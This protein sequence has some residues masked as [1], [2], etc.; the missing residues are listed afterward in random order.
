[1]A[2]SVQLPLP[3]GDA[4]TELAELIGCSTPDGAAVDRMCAALANVA[5][6]WWRRQ[7]QKKG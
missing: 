3:L 2:D 1:M 6:D 4:T 5:A 7:A